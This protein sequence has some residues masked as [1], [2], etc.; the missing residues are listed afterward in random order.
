LPSVVTFLAAL[1]RYREMIWAMSKHDLMSRYV[2]TFGGPLWAIVHPLA[3]VVIY[4]FVFSLGFKAAGPA[5]TPFVLYLVSGLVPWLLFNNTLASSATAV[6]RNVHLVK[7]TVFPTEILPIVHLVSETFP[8][9]AMLSILCGLTWFYGYEPSFLL[10]QVAYFYGAL[11]FFVLGLAWLFSA[12][13]VFHRDLGQAL[14]VTLSLWFWLTPVVW[15]RDMIP[16]EYRWI[17]DYNPTSYVV[18]GYRSSLL[19]GYPFWADWTSA[20]RFWVLTGAIFL[21][22]VYVFRRL[23]PEFAD[24]L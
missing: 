18:Q 15:T 11:A 10:F 23:R 6:T 22:G 13:Q 7:K 3:S 8:H 5:E 16:R 24:V 20:L 21:L 19:L 9:V 14:V 2:G 1:Y 12:L 4:W 17:A